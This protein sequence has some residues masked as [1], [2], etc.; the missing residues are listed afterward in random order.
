MSNVTILLQDTTKICLQTN[1]TSRE[2]FD[3]AEYQYLHNNPFFTIVQYSCDKESIAI[4]FDQ[5]VMIS[6]S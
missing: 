3:L 5:I 6:V 2:L 1:L 4:R